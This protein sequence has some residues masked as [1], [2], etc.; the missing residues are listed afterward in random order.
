MNHI[1]ELRQARLSF[2]GS[3]TPTEFYAELIKN[4][5]SADEISGVPCSLLYTIFC[6]W[7]DE[8]GYVLPNEK[9]IGHALTTA[10]GIKSKSKRVNGIA[11][12]IYYQNV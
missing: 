4:F 7:C 5:A 11:T 1:E 10:Y 6:K 2:E 3:Q 9:L 8:N 12:K